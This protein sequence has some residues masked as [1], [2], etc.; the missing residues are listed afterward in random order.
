M[1]EALNVAIEFILY[2]ASINK[3]NTAVPAAV[4]KTI[5]AVVKALIP[6]I[7]FTP[8]IS[9]H[10]EEPSTFA[11]PLHIPIKPRKKNAEIGLS[12]EKRIMAEINNGRFI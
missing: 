12:N 8:Y 3:P 7:N 4:A 5:N 11:R 6:P 1:Y 2:P 9:A 10:S